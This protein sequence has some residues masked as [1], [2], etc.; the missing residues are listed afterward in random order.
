MFNDC[1]INGMSPSGEPFSIEDMRF[2]RA[3]A[4][5]VVLLVRPTVPPAYSTTVSMATIQQRLYFLIVSSL[6]SVL[7]WLGLAVSVVRPMK[8]SAAKNGR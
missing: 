4:G 1:V 8:T 6:L 5:P 2:G 3:P 7:F